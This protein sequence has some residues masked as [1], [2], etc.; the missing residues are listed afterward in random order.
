[1]ND[2]FSRLDALL[3]EASAKH[4]VDGVPD[5][6]SAVAREIRR[7]KD[8]SFW[9]RILRGANKEDA[10]RLRPGL[11]AAAAGVAVAIG[12]AVPAQLDAYAQES[13]A[14]NAVF[15][16]SFAPPAY[17]WDA[18]PSSANVDFQR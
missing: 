4:A 17:P 9:R 12:V 11:V 1:M 2:D 14:A 15:L 13:T 16:D 6:H 7:R 10:F 8:E 5:L 18:P 3:R